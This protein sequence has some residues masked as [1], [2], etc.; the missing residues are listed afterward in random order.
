M[1]VGA[2]DQPQKY[3]AIGP[4]QCRHRPA[5]GQPFRDVA[6]RTAGAEHPTTVFVGCGACKIVPLKV[7]SDSLTNLSQSTALGIY[8]GRVLKACCA[9]YAQRACA[10]CFMPSSKAISSLGCVSL[11][12]RPRRILLHQTRYQGLVL[13]LWWQTF[14]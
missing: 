8:A 1:C 4:A 2:S 12:S 6:A 7:Q 14:L 9:S 3:V 11:M 5:G 10:A 13:G